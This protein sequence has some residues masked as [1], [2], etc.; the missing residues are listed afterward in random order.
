M[1][2]TGRGRHWFS[3]REWNRVV[4][5]QTMRIDHMERVIRRLERRVSELRD[6]RDNWRGEARGLGRQLA[7][8]K[9][10]P[11]KSHVCRNGMRIAGA[12]GETYYPSSDLAERKRRL[13]ELGA[14]ATAAP[15]GE[16]PPC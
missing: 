7:D 10:E 1:M 2:E 3:A 13:L 9:G 6:H 5:E 16:E 4:A 14:Q 12:I 11:V 15:I 8:L